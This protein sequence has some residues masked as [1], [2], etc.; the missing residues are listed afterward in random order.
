MKSVEKV[1]D[2][3]CV[4]STLVFFLASAGMVLGQAIGILSLNGSLS[5]SIS[6]MIA[7][8]A[9]LVSAVT[10]VLALALAYMRGQMKE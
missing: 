5:V 4:I 8:R 3:L 7:Q 10:V 2:I 1:I 9:G 6:D